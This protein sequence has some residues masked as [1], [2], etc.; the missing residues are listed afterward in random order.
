MVVC[1]FDRR[2]AMF[3]WPLKVEAVSSVTFKVVFIFSVN[4]EMTVIFSV[5]RGADPSSHFPFPKQCKQGTL[6]SDHGPSGN[7]AGTSICCISRS[8]SNTVF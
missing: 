7:R 2:V 8:L 6:A 1:A 4:C 5:K 3:V